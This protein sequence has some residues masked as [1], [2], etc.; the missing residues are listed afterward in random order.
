[1]HF[2]FEYLQYLMNESFS[3]LAMFLAFAVSAPIM[4]K[5]RFG[6]LIILASAVILWVTCTLDMRFDGGNTAVRYLEFFFVIPWVMICFRDS[7]L[8]RLICSALFMFVW[9]IAE[10]LTE[11]IFGRLS[12][13]K[14]Y[15][16]Q[17]YV[18]LSFVA[19][20]CIIILA[21]TAIW[22][23]LSKKSSSA[24]SFANII[25]LFTVILAETIIVCVNCVILFGRNKAGDSV[26]LNIIISLVLGFLFLDIMAFVYTRNAVRLQNL[27]AEYEILSAENRIQADYY[28]K[29]RESAD[30]A[31]KIRHDINNLITVI[32]LLLKSKT[33]EDIQK[34]SELAIGLKQNADAARIPSV[35]NNRL[36]NL[37]LYDKL[38]TAQSAGIS[39]SDNIILS[40]NCGI[41]DIDLCRVFV[42]LIDNGINALKECHRG[43]T[44]LYVSCRESGGV[45]YIKTVNAIDSAVKKEKR[46]NHGYGLRIIKDICEKYD[47]NITTENNGQSFTV[48]VALNT[49]K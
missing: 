5:P 43:D 12:G 8:N 2:L 15:F 45:L 41:D 31:A 13:I 6:R 28:T 20:A 14:H 48:L 36:V 44:E 40:D 33:D 46:K 27:N 42:N 4:L 35:C 38:R 30:S 7:A 49:A 39:I 37:I 34:A 29:I 19:F 18:C 23:R 1:M 22:V 16:G 10:A 47:G 11:L 9:F 17:P 32:Q 26:G 24:G 21:I 25:A 3:L